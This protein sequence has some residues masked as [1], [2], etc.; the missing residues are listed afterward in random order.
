MQH[1]H[2]TTYHL[3]AEEKGGGT[4]VSDMPDIMLTIKPRHLRHMKEGRKKYELRKTRPTLCK[5]ANHFTRIWCC[6]S[7]SGGRVVATFRTR[8]YQDMTKASDRKIAELAC[9]TEDEVR[10]YRQSGRSRM[11]GWL[12]EDFEDIKGTDR[13]RHIADFGLKRP[14]QSWCYCHDQRGGT[15]V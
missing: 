15:E 4:D 13:E 1:E 12:V 7:G 11:Y 8:A 2:T 10:G 6:E 5:L 3:T 14:P 9:I